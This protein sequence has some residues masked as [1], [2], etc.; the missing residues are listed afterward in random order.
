M[1]ILPERAFNNK[2]LIIKI[3]E[4]DIFRSYFDRVFGGWLC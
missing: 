3:Y 1:K 2:P 4:K